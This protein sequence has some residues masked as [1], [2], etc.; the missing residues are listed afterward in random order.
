VEAIVEVEGKTQ[1]KR[2]LE[3]R[4]EMALEGMG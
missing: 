2:P 1:E 4:E 3:S